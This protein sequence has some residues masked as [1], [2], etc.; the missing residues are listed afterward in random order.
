ML[1]LHHLIFIC[2]LLITSRRFDSRLLLG[3]GSSGLGLLS[4]GFI[5]LALVIAISIRLGVFAVRCG[6]V[7]AFAT[8]CARCGSGFL[9]SRGSRVGGG[10]RGCGGGS[11]GESFGFFLQLV[12]SLT[13]VEEKDRLAKSL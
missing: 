8:R 9:I 2:A 5:I 13:V 3:S 11:V 10:G 7:L 4:R 6:L 12:E 1:L